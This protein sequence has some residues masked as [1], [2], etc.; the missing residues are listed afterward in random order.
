MTTDGATTGGATTGGTV[1][2]PDRLRSLLGTPPAW[3]TPR[4][5][6]W[7]ASEAWL[8]LALPADYK[9]FLDLYGPGSVD[10]YLELDRPTDG[11]S[12]EA[13]R[14]WSTGAADGAAPVPGPWPPHPAEGGLVPW[15]ADAHGNRYWFLTEEPDPDDWRI[16][17]ESEAGEWFET[18]GTFTDFLL[19]CFDRIDRPPFLARAWPTAGARYHPYAP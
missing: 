8:G 3:G 10:G 12:A 13:D 6:L 19:R 17:V 18:A 1:A 7:A 11:G 16:V 9:A 2:V 5:S 4:P 14:L 15:G